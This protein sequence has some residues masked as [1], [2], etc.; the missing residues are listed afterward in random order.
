MTES[1]IDGPLPRDGQQVGTY[2]ALVPYVRRPLFLTILSERISAVVTHWLT[3]HEA[4][5]N[6]RMVRC[7]WEDCNYCRQGRQRRWAGYLMCWEHA[8]GIYCLCKFSWDGA[9]ILLGMFPP[10]K[11]LRGQQVEMVRLGESNKNPIWWQHGTRRAL[12][13]LPACPDITPSLVKMYGHEIVE[14]SR[15]WKEGEQ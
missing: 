4:P 15:R 11:P 2:K 14:I 9:G 7:D 1:R 13:P 5:P 8:L 10:P 6:G 3:D 12:D